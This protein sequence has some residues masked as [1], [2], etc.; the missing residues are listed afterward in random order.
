MAKLKGFTPAVDALTIKYGIIT[1][2][3][4]GRM[5][6]FA[7]MS[8]L[9]ICSASQEKIGE[10]LGLDRTTVNRHI[11]ILKEKGLIRESGRSGGGTV[12]YIPLVD[13]H[14]SVEMD[15]AENDTESAVK[16]QSDV[17]KSNTKKDS[18]K[19]LKN[20]TAEA[21]KRGAKLSTAIQVDFQ[22]HLGL[23][24][25]WDTKTNQVHYQ[26]FRARYE[27]GETAKDFIKWWRSD[28]KGKDGSMP[29]S[30]NQVQTLWLQ[31]FTKP[32]N[33]LEAENQRL[34]EL[35]G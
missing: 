27:V 4:Y 35:H 20:N 3:I 2:S 23:S 14:V 31:A 21:I 29:S 25:N 18:K 28:W 32:T 11:K 17:L 30:L 16:Q 13:I 5:W 1:S 19:V 22:Q 26:F 10:Y 12:T 8:D 15:V 7:K 6:R 34:K 24:P 9:N 33:D